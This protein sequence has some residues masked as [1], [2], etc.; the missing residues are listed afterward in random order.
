MQ[1]VFT[2]LKQSLEILNVHS[3][4][5]LDRVFLT[6]DMNAA[7]LA[8]N[9]TVGVDP[10]GKGGLNGKLRGCIWRDTLEHIVLSLEGCRQ[11]KKDQK[12]GQIAHG[13]HIQQSVVCH[14]IGSKHKAAAF[15]AVEH[16]GGKEHISEV[17]RFAVYCELARHG[18]C[19][20]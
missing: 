3:A 6:G 9:L 15:E 4:Q 16:T 13:T 14:G 8:C 20:K 1:W 11:R 17:I 2:V 5:Y 7:A 12:L 19:S 10:E 18:R